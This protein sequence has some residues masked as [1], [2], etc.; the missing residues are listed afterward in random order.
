MINELKANREITYTGLEKI[1]DNMKHR[2]DTMHGTD[3]TIDLI[4]D[5]FAGDD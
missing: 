3:L 4:T 5:R 1:A 2:S